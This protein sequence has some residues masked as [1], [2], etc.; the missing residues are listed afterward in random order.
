VDA[1]RIEEED[2]AQHFRH[3]ALKEEHQRAERIS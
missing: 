2:G 1:I 3:I